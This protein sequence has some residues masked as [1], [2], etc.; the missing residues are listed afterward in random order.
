MKEK[1]KA[2]DQSFPSLKDLTPVIVADDE[3]SQFPTEATEWFRDKNILKLIVPVELGGE[4]SSI[5]EL[6]FLG[7]S[8]SRRNLTTSVAFGQSLLGSL[9]LWIYGTT[10]QKKR[11]AELFLKNYSCCLALTEKTHGSDLSASEVFLDKEHFLT[12]EK[13]CIN[14]GTL[15]KSL[16]VLVSTDD[17]LTILFLEKEKLDQNS[18]EHLNKI[19]T[20]GIKGADI[21]GVRFNS[22]LVAT[23]SV[24]YKKG[25][26][27][28]VVSKTMQ[29]SRTLC[30][31]FSL[32]AIDTTLRMGAHFLLNRKLYNKPLYEVNAC[33]M[34]YKKSFLSCLAAEAI[35]NVVTRAISLYPEGMS[36]YSAICKNM[37]T[38][39]VDKSILNIGELLGARS[40]LKE[41]GYSLF[42]K[43][44]RDHSVVSI[45]DGSSAINLFLVGGQFKNILRHIDAQSSDEYL[46]VFQHRGE[47][48]NFNGEGLRL[49]NRGFDFIFKSY[50]NFSSDIPKTITLKID[51]AIKD[52]IKKIKS[53]EGAQSD[54]YQVRIAAQMY[55]DV[56][57]ACLYISF[58]MMNK[59]SMHEK[60]ANNGLLEA[61]V[62]EIL[63][64]ENEDDNLFGAFD[65]L[66]KGRLFSHFDYKV[67]ED[68][69]CFNL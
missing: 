40:Y 66:T 62:N 52:L 50:Y 57:S 33:L 12:G 8:I 35:A 58:F 54:S 20:Y 9:P 61:V 28:E 63:G 44:K 38:G 24:V 37:V 51:L 15:S 47:V 39:L 59:D 10:E 3:K 17:G 19:K 1:F 46:D 18:F 56:S 42:E 7:R 26:G 30:S 2:W 21:S 16:T 45:F 11:Q 25:R 6:F 29:V 13:W 55:C 64:I 5:E 31:I 60:L 53:C 32:G 41:E 67:F 22:C 43:I 4:L 49:T 65:N 69:K 14:N 36:L 48:P 34:L 68:E 27:L 23:D